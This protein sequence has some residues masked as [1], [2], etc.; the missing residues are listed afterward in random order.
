MGP[1]SVFLWYLLLNLYWKLKGVNNKTEGVN[2]KRTLGTL[3]VWT[4]YLD[5]NKGTLC[6]STG[7]AFSRVSP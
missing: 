4:L 7:C 3:I 2:S 6:I 5:K 1:L